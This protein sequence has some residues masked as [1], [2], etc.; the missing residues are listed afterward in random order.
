MILAFGKCHISSQN[1][2]FLQASQSLENCICV[3]TLMWL[4]KTTTCVF[5]WPESKVYMYADVCGHVCLWLGVCFVC[6][7]MGSQTN[8][9][10]LSPHS[11]SFTKQTSLNLWSDLYLCLWI[12]KP[13]HKQQ[14]CHIFSLLCFLSPLTSHNVA[15][16]TVQIHLCFTSMRIEIF[17]QCIH[18]SMYLFRLCL[19]ILPTSLNALAS[20]K[21]CFLCLTVIKIHTGRHEAINGGFYAT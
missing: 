13:Q 18:P 15:Q 2:T 6:L 19:P 5:V 17:I 4:L 10:S 16:S 8:A 7:E 3:R 1:V 12:N 11:V 21:D 14:S 20:D 9:A